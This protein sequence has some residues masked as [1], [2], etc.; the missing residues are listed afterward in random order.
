MALINSRGRNNDG[1]VTLVD[2]ALSGVVAF[3]AVMI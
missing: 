2:V 3:K 1:S